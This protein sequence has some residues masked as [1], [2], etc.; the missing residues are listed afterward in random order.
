[1]AGKTGGVENEEVKAEE[2]EEE[3]DDDSDVSFDLSHEDEETIICPWIEEDDVPQLLLPRP[4][5]DLI[6][7]FN[8][9][10]DL[11]QVYETVTTYYRLIQ[12]TPFLFEDFCAAMRV[13]STTKLVA[14]I[15]IAL[16]KALLRDDEEQQ[17][18]YA[19]TETS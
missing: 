1:M 19:V 15:H 17:T 14:D 12:I 11:I 9:L 2:E 13:E 16:L 5:H 3:D 10:M 6:V 4:C 8:L 7:S 18:L